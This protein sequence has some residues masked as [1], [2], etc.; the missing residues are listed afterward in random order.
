M[1]GGYDIDK[2][3][4][5]EPELYAEYKAQIEDACDPDYAYD[6]W[7]YAQDDVD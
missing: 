7:R 5:D 4:G 2:L 6:A 3:H 1:W